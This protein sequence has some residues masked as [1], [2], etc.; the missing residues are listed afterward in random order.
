MEVLENYAHIS[1][2][3]RQLGG[4]RG[5]S[6]AQ[7]AEMADVRA[8]FGLSPVRMPRGLSVTKN[9]GHVVPRTS[10]AKEER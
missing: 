5:L 9:V 7:V 4:G 8:G 10:S 1:Y 6:E 2:I 3:V